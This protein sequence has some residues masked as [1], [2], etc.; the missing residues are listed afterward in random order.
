MP[1]MNSIRVS[2]SRWVARLNF[3]R[4]LVLIAMQRGHF[5]QV[6]RTSQA[7]VREVFCGIAGRIAPNSIQA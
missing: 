7:G 5:F 6:G 4:V 2:R 1:S 3:F